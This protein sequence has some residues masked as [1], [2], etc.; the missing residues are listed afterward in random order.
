[1]VRFNEILKY[2]ICW[3]NLLLQA[4]GDPLILC[5]VDFVSP[6]H[7]ATAMDALQGQIDLT[8]KF[9]QTCIIVHLR[10]LYLSTVFL[11]YLSCVVPQV[12]NVHVNSIVSVDKYMVVIV[13]FFFHS[14]VS[15][16]IFTLHSL[17]WFIWGLFFAQTCHFTY[18]N[19]VGRI[20]LPI[21][22]K[23]LID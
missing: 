6:A 23:P 17:L 5:F 22:R 12:N 10:F 11:I 4:G 14:F 3:P 1:M 15:I 20:V 13:M 21:S 7:A 9:S 18:M 16:S 2:F 8:F 19:H